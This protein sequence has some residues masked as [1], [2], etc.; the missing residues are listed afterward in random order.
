MPY[1][2]KYKIHTDMPWRKIL[3]LEEAKA[4]PEFWP[5]KIGSSKYAKRKMEGRDEDQLEVYDYKEGYT[6]GACSWKSFEIQQL[7]I[8]FISPYNGKREVKPYV[9]T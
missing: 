7:H 4:L 1:V 3:S 6:L 2:N 8:G 5:L 9:K